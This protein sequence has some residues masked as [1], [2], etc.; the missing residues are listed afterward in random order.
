[1]AMIPNYKKIIKK[2][3]ADL[4]SDLCHFE[5]NLQTEREG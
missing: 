4:Q 2:F 5:K 3:T 1:M